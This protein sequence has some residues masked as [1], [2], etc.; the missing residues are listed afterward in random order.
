VKRDP[1]AAPLGHSSADA[2]GGTNGAV[3]PSPVSSLA[4]SNDGKLLGCGRINGEV[5]IMWLDTLEWCG[6]AQAHFS[7]SSARVR[8]LAFDPTSR[9]LIS[10][11]DDNH[12]SVLNAERWASSRTKSSLNAPK[13]LPVLERVAAHRGWITSLSTCPDIRQRFLLTTSMD[14]TV[15]LWDYVNHRLMKPPPEVK[16]GGAEDRERAHV[17][18]VMDA[19]WAPSSNA[20]FYVTV[21]SDAALAL[22]TLTAEAKEKMVIGGVR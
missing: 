17:G 1:G 15:R 20:P 18:E 11:G 22:Y 8:G 19:A 16:R 21:G 3:P 9:F 6:H 12:F 5:G 13:P 4:L 7:Q 10:G 2:N 14:K